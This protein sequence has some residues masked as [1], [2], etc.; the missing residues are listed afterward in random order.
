MLNVPLLKGTLGSDTN[1]KLCWQTTQAVQ[2]QVWAA[3]FLCIELLSYGFHGFACYDVTLIHLLGEVYRGHL[4]PWKPED[5]ITL[6]V[7]VF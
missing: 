5:K 3:D 1:T 6:V 2:L 7:S 4:S